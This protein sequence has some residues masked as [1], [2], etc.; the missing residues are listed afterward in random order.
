MALEESK[1][2]MA[3]DYKPVNRSTSSMVSFKSAEIVG[4]AVEYDEKDRLSQLDEE[5]ESRLH[6]QLL[7]E[8]LKAGLVQAQVRRAEVGIGGFL[9]SVWKHARSLMHGL[10]SSGTTAGEFPCHTGPP[11]SILES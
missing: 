1:D 10:L 4:M 9:L 3:S 6:C 2:H 8:E 11:N 5:S 7:S